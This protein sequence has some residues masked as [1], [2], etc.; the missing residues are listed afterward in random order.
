MTTRL[1]TAHFG[2]VG[3]A[4]VLLLSLAAA[5]AAAQSFGGDQGSSSRHVSVS[6]GNGP[7]SSVTVTYNP[8]DTQGVGP[9]APGTIRFGGR[10]SG[11]GGNAD[12]DADATTGGGTGAGCVPTGVRVT[13]TVHLPGFGIQTS[14]PSQGVVG[15][16]TW[17]W[18][19]RY[20]GGQIPS[21]TVSG[22]Y[23]DCP[24]VPVPGATD[25]STEVVTR[26]HDLTLQ[27]D[28]W[29]V[30][31]VWDFGDGSRNAGTC[32]AANTPGSCAQ[33]A[34]GVANASEVNNVYLSSSADH[35]D[36]YS[37]ALTVTFGARIGING[38]WTFLGT[39]D[40]QAS[41]NYPVREIQ[42]VLVP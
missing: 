22:Y 15:V 34:L 40:Q 21:Q 25:G 3:L 8:S 42:T 36:G 32:A 7:T 13:G 27:V 30:G 4:V 1:R 37:I 24:R 26:R 20:A 35:P 11:Q 23:I 19:D 10:A 16:P 31:Y 29:P 18:S 6:P 14:P 41:L 9:A 12:D 17:L 2:A 5:P 28:V 39:F 33:Q 38:A